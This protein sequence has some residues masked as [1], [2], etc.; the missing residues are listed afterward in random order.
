MQ[1]DFTVDRSFSET[2]AAVAAW[3]RWWCS[4]LGEVEQRFRRDTVAAGVWTSVL[5]CPPI[6]VYAVLARPRTEAIALCVLCALASVGSLLLMR[7]PWDAFVAS[8]WREAYFGAWWV[9]DFVLIIT[10]TVLAGGPDSPL[11][12]LAFI[13]LVFTGLSYPKASV[14]LA[15]MITLSTVVGL[16]LV[17]A[18]PFTTVLIQ[19]TAFAA[20][21][22][23]S[24]L[25]ARN[26]DRRAEV[27]H[28]SEHRLAEAQ[29][30]AHVGSWEWRSDTGGLSVSEELRR[31]LDAPGSESLSTVEEYIDR[32]H[33]GDRDEVQRLMRSAIV[34]A[35]PFS[36]EHRIVRRDGRIRSVIVHG[37]ATVN[38]GWVTRLSGVC[39]DITK[40]RRVEARLRH[41][42]D[43][44]PLT[45]LLSRRR[46]VDEI[47]QRLGFGPRRARSGALLLIDLDGF[48]FYN[49]S[50]GQAVGD[51]LLRS[52]AETLVH[53]L[54]ATDIVARSGGDEFG[55]VLADTTRDAAVS[56]AQ[57]LRA[58]LS[59]CAGESTVTASIGIAA[60]GPD[61]ELVGDDVLVA[62]DIALH[63]AKHSGGNRVAM[64][65]G[66]TGPDM[67]WMQRI[68]RALEED[69]FVLLA[70]PIIDVTSGEVS[71]H[72]LLIR[73]RDDDGSLIA[74]GAFLPTAERFGLINAIDRWVG[75]TAVSL[76]GAG[77]RVALNL[78]AGSIGDSEIIRMVRTAAE[79]GVDPAMLIFEI[80]ETAAIAN[81]EEARQF[82]A[83]LAGIGC[84]LAIDDFGTGFGS[85]TYL[86]H[87][88]SRFVK[89]DREFIKDLAD[90]P[91]DQ[92]VVRA[93]VG[94]SR[95]LGQSTIAEG[96]ENAETL[97][98]VRKLG[99]DYVQGYFTG[100]PAR[101]W[102][103][104]KEPLEVDVAA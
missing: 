3:R 32:V 103:R 31:I 34:H 45:G 96:V 41:H 102:P 64:Y 87:I 10:A 21:G 72:E 52:I 19:L 89:I 22:L 37:N 77:H 75:R 38:N 47:D 57:E 12:L 48:G 29:Q 88:P 11:L 73:M 60:F 18:Q 91:T 33:A 78:S 95:S 61:S 80:T 97:A 14:V 62:A 71:H 20:T 56:T 53:R 30:I 93:V 42:A 2:G 26:H 24:Y 23:M 15:T 55:I 83:A 90:S 51:A 4:P 46:L 82:A 98:L 58:L 6:A 68:R 40:L 101:I 99:V 85:L 86:K 50:Y 9:I 28:R 27:L 39:Q 25:Q 7:L 79:E 65:R 100:R 67:T 36:F 70:Q 84:E 8:P 69:Q 76:A 17:Y 94:I 13:Q 16:S 5:V 54:R 44:D 66:Q 1:T 43:H 35:G 104:P 74:P 81:L 59:E 92:H 49:D 63:E